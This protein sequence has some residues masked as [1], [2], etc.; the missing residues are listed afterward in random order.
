VIEG[1]ERLVKDEDEQKTETV[2]DVE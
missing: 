2:E 1:L